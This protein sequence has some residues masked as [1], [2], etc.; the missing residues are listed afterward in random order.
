MWCLSTPSKII[1]E[2]TVKIWTGQLLLAFCY[3]DRLIHAGVVSKV[4]KVISVFN[5][6]SVPDK[7]GPCFSDGDGPPVHCRWY[8]HKS[9]WALFTRIIRQLLSYSLVWAHGS[10]TL[11]PLSQLSSQHFRKWSNLQVQLQPILHQWEFVC[12]TEMADV[13]GALCPGY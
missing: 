5:P 13:K 3:T 11:F 2:K 7:Q 9:Q 6:Q 4:L 10:R 1:E 8:D 12:G